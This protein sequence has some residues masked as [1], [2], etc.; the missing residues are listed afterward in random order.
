MGL[1]WLEKIQI[2]AVTTF[3]IIFGAHMTILFIIKLKIL[4]LIKWSYEGYV[5]L[6]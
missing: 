5:Y 6:K 2:K 3:P 4:M 1:K